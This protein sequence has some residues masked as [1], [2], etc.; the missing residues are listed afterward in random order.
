MSTNNGIEVISDELLE[1]CRQAVVAGIGY[2]TP[3]NQAAYIWI[4]YFGYVR[5]WNW[6]WNGDNTNYPDWQIDG[7]IPFCGY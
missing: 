4:P 6:N 7:Y 1:V 3:D 2:K 5:I